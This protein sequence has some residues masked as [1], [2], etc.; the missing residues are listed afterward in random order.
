M[1]AC[2]LPA[3]KWTSTYQRDR[4]PRRNYSA[5]N[6]TRHSWT[7]VAHLRTASARTARKRSRSMVKWR[8]NK[9][10]RLQTDS[11]FWLNEYDL[12]SFL[13]FV[14]SHVIL[15]SMSQGLTRLIESVQCTS[16]CPKGYK[17]ILISQIRKRSVVYRLVNCR[18]LSIRWMRRMNENGVC[19]VRDNLF[20]IWIHGIA[21]SVVV[22]CHDNTIEYTIGCEEQ[23]GKVG[24]QNAV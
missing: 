23:W 19:C 5:E 4:T 6:N 15:N 22:N 24:L 12:S 14:F 8:A 1:R 7:I 16:W 20:V 18:T 3:R 10:K 2:S 17:Y 9:S 11:Q 21:C 13:P